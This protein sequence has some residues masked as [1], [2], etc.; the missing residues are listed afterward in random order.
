MRKKRLLVRRI[1]HKRRNCTSLC[2]SINSTFIKPGSPRCA[3]EGSSK[4]PLKRY[5]SLAINRISTRHWLE[6]RSAMEWRTVVLPNSLTRV[7][8]ARDFPVLGLPNGLT[9]QSLQ[10]RFAQY[11]QHHDQVWDKARLQRLTRLQCNVHYCFVLNSYDI[12][13]VV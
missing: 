9:Q 3:A 11:S 4:S 7:T 5:S 13:D 12:R 6:R 10:A 8:F 2:K 1:G